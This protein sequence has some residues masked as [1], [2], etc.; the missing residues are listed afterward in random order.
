[1]LHCWG[2]FIDGFISILTT[3]WYVKPCSKVIHESVMHIK[4]L[5]SSK[6]FCKIGI[7]ALS[8]VFDKYYPI[9]N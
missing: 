6:I 3:C 1:M 7:V 5:F 8:F 2:Y 9:I 4:A